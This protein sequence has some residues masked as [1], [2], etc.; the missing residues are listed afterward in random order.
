MFNYQFQ[1]PKTILVNKASIHCKL[2][3]R[4]MSMT[5]STYHLNVQEIYVSCMCMW[6][7]WHNIN[8]FEHKIFLAKK[9]H[10]W[11]KKNWGLSTKSNPLV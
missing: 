5:V 9:I 3:M 1:F 4:Q 10:L 11:V 6:N 8:N 7:V 2:L